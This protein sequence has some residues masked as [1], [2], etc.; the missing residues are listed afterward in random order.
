M[1]PARWVAGPGARVPGGARGCPGAR[2]ARV[3]GPGARVPG[4]ARGCPG[5]RGARVPGCPGARV[6]Y[7]PIAL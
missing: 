1:W 4:G 6:P 7:S 2:G 5:A 3:A